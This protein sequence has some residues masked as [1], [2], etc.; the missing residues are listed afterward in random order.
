MKNRKMIF[1]FST[2]FALLIGSAIF[3]MAEPTPPKNVISKTHARIIALKEQKGK[4][5]DSELEFEDKI[6]IYSF[7]IMSNDKKS[8]E[9]NINALTGKVVSNVV[10]TAMM[11]A[12]EKKE[13]QGK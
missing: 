10:E 2:T 7:A 13:D 4:V 8:H 12:K 1:V 6:W 3:C 5:T 11:E 9:V